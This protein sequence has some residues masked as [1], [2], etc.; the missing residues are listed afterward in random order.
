MATISSIG[1][2]SGLKVED[3]ITSLVG[4]EKA[5]LK[6]LAAE[7]ATLDT[8]V[9]TYASIKSQ[10]SALND[11]AVT[12]GTAA[13][14]NPLTVSSSKTDSVTAAAVGVP[15]KASYSVEVQ[16]LARAQT[17]ASTTQTKDAAMGTGT[18]SITL[19]TWDATTLPG[20]FTAG[21]AA[22][23]DVDILPT[24]NTLTKIAAAINNAGAGVVA[25]VITDSAGER[26]S[27]RSSATGEAAGFRVQVTDTGDGNNTD[28][29]GLSRL[30]FDPENGA[31]SMGAINSATTLLGQD[32][33]ATLNGVAVQSSSNT[34]TGLVPGLN[35]TVAQ[36]TTAPVVVTVAQD[37]AAIK[38]SITNF[39]TAYNLLN[40]TLMENTRYDP[41]KKV[42]A[43]LQ[44][45][46][47]TVTLSNGLRSLLGSTT[48]GAAYSRL[49]DL[50]I[51][52]ATTV[53]AGQPDGRLVLDSAKVDD[54]LQDVDKVKTFFT[55][56]NKDLATNGFGLKLKTFTTGLLSSRGAVVAKQSALSKSIDANTDEQLKVTDRADAVE[57]RLRKTYSALDTKMG[58]L[59]ALSDYVT[60]QVA[61]WNK[62]T[63]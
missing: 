50:G 48:A 9:S 6:P 56:D 28:A 58:A 10:V 8:K 7:R 52:I 23:V 39:V 17:V 47:A 16:Q 63:D 24:D 54:A 15:A 31:V 49:S 2:G 13:L 42:G 12:L 4:L 21:A 53:E 26:L 20:S 45:D 32:A 27:L 61:T 38:K 57:A 25:T 35:L 60:Q 5:R 62:S 3:I 18:L 46:T 37:M 43:I 22:A 29:N 51:K 19:G 55:I 33:K 44:G 34:F 59:T 30:A 1:L 11:A 36:V 41:V 14:W 40:A